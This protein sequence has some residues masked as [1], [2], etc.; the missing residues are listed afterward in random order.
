M[1]EHRELLQAGSGSRDHPDVPAPHPVGEGERHPVDDRGAAIRSHDQEPAPAGLALELDLV[2]HRHVVAEEQNVQAQPQRAPRLVRGEGARNRDQREVRA[3][4]R[5]AGGA[6]SGE[7]KVGGFLGFGGAF[8]RFHRRLEGS[9]DR[10]APGRPDRDHQVVGSGAAPL[11]RQQARLVQYLEVGGNPDHEGR[12]PDAFAP[13]ERRRHSHECHR[14]EIEAAPNP[15][16]DDVFA[17]GTRSGPSAES[18]SASPERAR[19]KHAIGG[20]TTPAPT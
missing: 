9:I 14:V 11:R 17:H 15:V 4:Q 10:G 7:A 20:R 12:V 16:G 6:Q 3:R 18:V 13:G 1:D 5:L 8:E 19:S 2:L